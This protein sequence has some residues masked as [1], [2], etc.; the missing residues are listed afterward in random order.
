M[1]NDNGS[2]PKWTRWHTFERLAAE[3]DAFVSESLAR[4][5]QRIGIK[6]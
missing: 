5:A 3:H 2:K 6:F 1:L 4:I